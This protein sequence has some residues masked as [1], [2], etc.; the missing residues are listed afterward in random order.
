M[1][2]RLRRVCAQQQ[3][4]KLHRPVR[5]VQHKVR[6]V[7]DAQQVVVGLPEQCSLVRVC[8]V[9]LDVLWCAAY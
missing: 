8:E 2:S 9:S 3:T 6:E 5:A 1:H 4:L 7:A